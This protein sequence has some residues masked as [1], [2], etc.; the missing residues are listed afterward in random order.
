MTIDAI[1]TRYEDSEEIPIVVRRHREGELRELGRRKTKNE[2]SAEGTTLK[3]IGPNFLYKF[4]DE[5]QNFEFYFI[6]DKWDNIGV[7]I[8][9][10]REGH[11]CYPLWYNPMMFHFAVESNSKLITDKKEKIK[12]AL[13]GLM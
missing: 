2:I 9:V 7:S 12:L 10:W 13:R 11:S 4:S 3:K 1:P 6:I 8:R 5:N